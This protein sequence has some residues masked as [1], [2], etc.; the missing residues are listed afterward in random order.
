MVKYMSF[1]TFRVSIGVN[2]ASSKRETYYQRWRREHPRLQIYL[3]KEEYEWLKERADAKGVS[4]KDLVL[5][6]IKCERSV[7]LE[8]NLEFLRGF[9]R[10]LDL[11]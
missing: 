5:E 7:E 4:M 8:K 11:F 3:S 9:Y 1:S 2:V 10:A 6:A